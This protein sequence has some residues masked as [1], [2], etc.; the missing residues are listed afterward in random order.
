MTEGP[1][2]PLTPDRFKQALDEL[3]SMSLDAGMHYSEMIPVIEA[4]LA[5]MKADM[6]RIDRGG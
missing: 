4:E 3:I 6:A 2:T 1:K 5:Q